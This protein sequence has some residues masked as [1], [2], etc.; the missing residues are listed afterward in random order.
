MKT[1]IRPLYA[2]LLIGAVSISCIGK[3]TAQAG[4]DLPADITERTSA[5]YIEAYE[6]LTGKVFKIF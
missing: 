5:K 3:D 1:K 2:L 4:V 6:K